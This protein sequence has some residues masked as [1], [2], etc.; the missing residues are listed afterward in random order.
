MPVEPFVSPT[1]KLQFRG[2]EN[3][4]ARFHL[5]GSECCLIHADNPL[6]RDLGVYVNP[7]VRVGYDVTAYERANPSNGMWLSSFSIF[8]GIWT[9]RLSGWL[10]WVYEDT[11][12][13]SRVRKRLRQ[14]EKESP[15]N[16][17]PGDFCLINEMQVIVWNGW[18]HV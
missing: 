11:L 10:V 7:R 5:E 4:L 17:E 3:S 9:N 14:W 12:V 1:K 2:I 8:W 18:A 6:T 16:H 15:D 13:K